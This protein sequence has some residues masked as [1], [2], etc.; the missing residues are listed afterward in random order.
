MRWAILLVA[1]VAAQAQSTITVTASRPVNP[2]LDQAVVSVTVNA[3]VTAGPDDVLA[4]LAGSGATLSMLSPAY[5]PGAWSFTMP[6]EFSG[7]KTVLAA[8]TADQ[9]AG[10]NSG[11]DVQ[12]SVS[13]SQ[14]SSSGQTCPYTALFGDAQAQARAVAAAAGMKVGA[15]IRLSDGSDVEQN[16]PTLAYRSG[17]F[18]AL[19][20]NSLTA[21]WYAPSALI[22][23]PISTPACTMVVQ[24]QLM[25]L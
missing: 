13:G 9:Q 25:S 20:V 18:S 7:L 1:G 10:Q 21:S 4:A 17:D 5:V 8:L 11:F 14:S 23:S 16:M 3:P 12:F 2:Q 24:F 22:T 6:V 19:L 15:V